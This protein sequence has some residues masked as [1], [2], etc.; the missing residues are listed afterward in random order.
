M[1]REKIELAKIS[2]NSLNR[3][4]KKKQDYLENGIKLIKRNSSLLKS[5]RKRSS[6][7]I[8]SPTKIRASIIGTNNNNNNNNEDKKLMKVKI[9]S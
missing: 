2:L 5:P 4:L 7:L 3:E 1:S 6:M 8:S 9:I